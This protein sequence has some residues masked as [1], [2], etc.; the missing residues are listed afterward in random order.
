[1]GMPKTRQDL[2]E[3]LQVRVSKEA[4][5]MIEDAADADKTSAAEFMRRAL[6]QAARMKLGR[7]SR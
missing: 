1:M 2:S 3:L 7:R 6:Y 4:K 5:K